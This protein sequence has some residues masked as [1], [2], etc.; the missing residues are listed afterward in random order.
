MIKKIFILPLIIS[1]AFLICGTD[2]AAS[3]INYHQDKAVNSFIKELVKEGY[4]DTKTLKRLFSQVTYKQSIIDAISRSAEKT[5]TWAQYRRLF[6]DKQRIRLGAS[7]IKDNIEVFINIEQS[8]GVPANIIAAIIGVETK[9]GLIMGN[10]RVIDS[11]TTLGFNYP[12]RSKFF[13]SELKHFLKICFDQNKNPL[14]FVGSYAGAMGYGQFMPSSYRSYAVDYDKD[15][16]KD[17]WTNKS[18]AIAS[19]A[20]YLSKHGWQSS[21]MIAY[22]IKDSSSLDLS[23]VDAKLKPSRSYL[24]LSKL[25]SGLPVV[26]KNMYKKKVSLIHL[27]GTKGS[28]YWLGFPN[29]YTITRYNR[30]NLYAMAVVHLAEAIDDYYQSQL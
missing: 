13:K 3:E 27:E 11:L 6:L 28:E 19:V 4:Y 16:F 1:L 9:Y 29:F 15:N 8:T 7:F 25:I 21:N 24:Q 18:D 2:I 12:K 14:D 20:N 23:M 17:L 30:S 26:D 5:L 22:K 10:Y